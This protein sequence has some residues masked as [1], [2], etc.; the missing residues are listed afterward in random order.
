MLG[1]TEVGLYCPRCCGVGVTLYTCPNCPEPLGRTNAAN[2]TSGT[3]P[4]IDE[5]YR[6][7]MRRWVRSLLPAS[8]YVKTLTKAVFNQI[9]RVCSNP[10]TGRALIYFSNRRVLSK[11]YIRAFLDHRV[12]EISEPLK[13]R[14]EKTMRELRAVGFSNMKNYLSFGK[15]GISW[16]ESE[17][18]TDEQLAAVSQ[19]S[20]TITQHGGT[21]SIKLH[22]KV[23]AL[24][25][26][27]QT[28]KLFA[29][30]KLKDLSIAVQVVNVR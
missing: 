27:G 12:D 5:E 8:H 14:A 3:R 24:I 25:K 28:A 20:E 2:A 11:P 1:R 9:T 23:E 17:D 21:R 4:G 22:S 18:L 15:A 16:K 30:D 7:A 19:V 6:K 26:Y 13:I 10:L 29:E